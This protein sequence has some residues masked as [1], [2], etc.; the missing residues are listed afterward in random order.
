MLWFKFIIYDKDTNQTGLKVDKPTYKNSN[1][2]NLH[3]LY[4]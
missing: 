4:Q 2:H 3:I 1:H